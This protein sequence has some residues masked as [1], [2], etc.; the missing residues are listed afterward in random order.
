M[1]KNLDKSQIDVASPIREGLEWLGEGESMACCVN[2]WM[3][4]LGWR[5]RGAQ[6]LWVMNKESRWEYGDRMK[7]ASSG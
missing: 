2:A 5:Q 7:V 4:E 6:V 3:Q 1:I